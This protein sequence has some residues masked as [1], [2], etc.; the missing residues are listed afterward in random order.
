MKNSDPIPLAACGASIL[1]SSA[2]DLRP[3]NVPVALTPLLLTDCAR[4]ESGSGSDM[5][6]QHQQLD[7][8]G[9]SG[10]LLSSDALHYYP[11]LGGVAASAGF[12]PYAP[13]RGQ[14]PPHH[15][16]AAHHAHLSAAAGPYQPYMPV[17]PAEL[18]DYSSTSAFFHSNVFK[19]A[20]AASQIRTKSHSSSGTHARCFHIHGGAGPQ[21]PS[22]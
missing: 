14:H 7:Y 5:K 21:V 17:P 8:S 13:P 2:L 10:A 19:A 15:P 18:A 9:V 1:A 6:Q 22:F 20:A 3:R 4:Y 11:H 16:G 12:S